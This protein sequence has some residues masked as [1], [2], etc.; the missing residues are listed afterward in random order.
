MHTRSSHKAKRSTSRGPAHEA[1]NTAA[2]VALLVPLAG[3]AMDPRF[4]DANGDLVADAPTDPKQW[5]DPPP[6]S[7]PTRPLKTPPCTPRSG[8]ASSITWPRSPASGAVLP[9]AKQRRAARGHA[10]GPPARGRLQHRLQPAGRELRRLRALR[11]DG[12]QGQPLRLRDGDHHLPGQRH[13]QGRGHQGQA[14]GLHVRDLQLGLQGAVGPA[15]RPVQDG[16]RQGLHAGLQRQARQLHPGRGQ[17]GLPGRGHRQ[18]GQD[19]HGSA[20]CVVKP[21]QTKVIY[22]S[23]TFPTTGYGHVYNLKPELAEKVKQAFFSFNWE[24]TALAAEFNK[25]S[26]RRRSSCPSPT[27]STGRWCATSTRPWA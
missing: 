14:H 23:Q 13:R 22:K 5:I 17:Q 11:D 8:T 25:P 10:R 1:V 9:G 16:S 3:Q 4:K 19:P 27:S 15:A 20:R 18:L 26:R 7:L 12:Q 24:G 2:A 21:E 6:W